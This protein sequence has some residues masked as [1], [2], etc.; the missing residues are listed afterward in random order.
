M[1]SSRE[2]SDNACLSDNF[3][4]VLAAIVRYF[5]GIGQPGSSK[6]R[7]CLIPVRNRTSWATIRIEL[8]DKPDLS[9]FLQKILQYR[10]VLRQFRMES[11]N[12]NLVVFGRYNLSV[13][14]CE[15]ADFL[16]DGAD[17]RGADEDGF[18]RLCYAFKRQQGFET[19]DL[20]PEAVPFDFDIYE[21]EPQFF[22]NMIAVRAAK[23]QP[24]TGSKN[25]FAG[26]MELPQRFLEMLFA[27]QTADGGRF[28]AW[29][30]QPILAVQI[31]GKFHGCR[32]DTQLSQGLQVLCDGTL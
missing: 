14:A 29:D 17:V 25:R 3:V 4:L 1:L 9:D 32:N 21:A 20:A 5:G 13:D 27:D 8:S 7:T 30:N 6:G 23:N 10:Q 26:S 15:H 28:A 2:L 24:G 11:S 31:D 16:S 22:W 12:Q 18:H 19:I